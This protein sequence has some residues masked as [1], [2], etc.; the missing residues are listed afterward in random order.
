MNQA[1][2]KRAWT[3]DEL[4]AA[5][6]LYCQLPFGKLHK[7][8]PQIVQLARL[9]DRSASSVGM[10]L[11]NF[12]SFDPAITATGRVGL[13]AASRLDKQ[14]WDE[15]NA[16]WEDMASESQTVLERLAASRGEVLPPLEDVLDTQ[17]AFA[18][19][20]TRAATVRVRMNQAF[21]RRTVLAS[22]TGQCCV[23]GLSQPSLL[24]ASHIVP[25]GKDKANRLN[26][27]NGLLL[28]VL[29]DKAFD[30]GLMTIG[31]DH[32]VV[33]S[34]VLKHNPDAFSRQVFMPLE[35]QRMSL[36]ERFEP[37]PA[38]LAHHRENIFVGA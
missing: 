34:G 3:R 20:R 15:F 16:D 14:I 37:D 10:K 6:N 13:K 27:R 23:S 32:K 35:G 31:E 24:V 11:V 19:G 4:I 17:D 2:A 28:S 30:R 7:T 38:L 5:F 9:L 29:H 22:Y 8:N 26:P 33:L 21:F 36:P 18:E 1:I 12:A 25:W